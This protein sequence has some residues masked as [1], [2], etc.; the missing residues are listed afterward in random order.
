M[1]DVIILTGSEVDEAKR[2]TI[3]LLS[4]YYYAPSAWNKIKKENSFVRCAK[5][6]FD[7]NQHKSQIKMPPTIPVSLVNSEIVD[8]LK[9][10]GNCS[11]N[12]TIS[13]MIN[14]RNGP[15]AVC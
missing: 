10:S 1:Y 7:A 11:I 4:Q 15:I 6:N 12:S 3:R 8:L 9:S 2:I 14:D 5:L 13:A